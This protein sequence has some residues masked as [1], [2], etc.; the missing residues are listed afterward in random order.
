MYTHRFSGA[1]IYSRHYDQFYDQCL[2]S[3]PSIV[4]AFKLPTSPREKNCA[5]AKTR[6]E[7]FKGEDKRVRCTCNLPRNSFYSAQPAQEC[8]YLS[9]P[10]R[11][12]SGLEP[13]K[14]AALCPDSRI[15]LICLSETISSYDRCYRWNTH[16]LRHTEGSS[17][18][19]DELPCRAIFTNL[20]LGPKGTRRRRRRGGRRER[21]GHRR[22]IPSDALRRGFLLSHGGSEHPFR[23]PKV[24]F[25]Y[26]LKKKTRSNA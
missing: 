4:P 5:K 16:V 9:V 1:I 12:P 13:W 24:E 21:N 8:G 15:P 22:R 14:P 6:D 26:Y 7:E 11:K 20:P 17:Q 23:T 2:R 19:S 18:P 10:R 3:A 25:V